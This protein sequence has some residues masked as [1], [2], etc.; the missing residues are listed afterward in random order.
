MP[1]ACL[2]Y[3]SPHQELQGVHRGYTAKGYV[4]PAADSL[5]SMAVNSFN[6]LQL[7]CA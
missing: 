2:N 3:S 4:V 5:H 7:S 1:F 6:R